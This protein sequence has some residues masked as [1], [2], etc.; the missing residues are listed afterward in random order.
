MFRYGKNEVYV[1]TTRFSGETWSLNKQ[2]RERRGKHGCL[3]GQPRAPSAEVP[4]NA[5]MMVIE[6]NNDALP[7]GLDRGGQTGPRGRV[8]GIGLCINKPLSARIAVYGQRR[9][10][11]VVYAG[12][13]RVDRSQIDVALSQRLDVLCFRGNCHL[14]RGIGFT[15]L[16]EG[17]LGRDLAVA[18]RGVFRGAHKRFL[19]Q[20]LGSGQVEAVSR[21]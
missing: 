6:M 3:Y 9:Y 19:A 12:R 1:M 18:L 2:W 7:S 15:S 13:Y 11:R 14:K 20:Q 8:E 17:W 21:P 16:P 4:E 5:V 10:D